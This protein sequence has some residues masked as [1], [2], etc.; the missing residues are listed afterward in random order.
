M[1]SPQM[2]AEPLAQDES[3]RLEG[4]PM[5]ILWTTPRVLC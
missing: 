4:L 3:E 2:P 1:G 5:G